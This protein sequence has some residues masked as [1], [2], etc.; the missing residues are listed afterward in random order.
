VQGTAPSIEGT[1]DV[2]V[3]FFHGVGKGSS[4]DV[5]RYVA[6]LDISVT[7]LRVLFAIEHGG[8]DLALHELAE[9]IGLSTAATGRAVDVLVRADLVTRME[10]PSDRRV[11]RIALTDKARDVMRRLN[12][13]RRDA[14]GEVVAT[15][16]PEERAQVVTALKT[17][18]D[19]MASS[20]PS[21]TDAEVTA[22]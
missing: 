15:L 10:D 5:F 18:L 21:T 1:T 19:R 16:T 3:E 8:R 17:M 11:K 20:D 22:P 2:L 6:E 13:A 7:Q 4:K 9:D 14:L 12:E